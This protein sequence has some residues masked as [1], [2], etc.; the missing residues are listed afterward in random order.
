MSAIFKNP[1]CFYNE[2]AERRKHKLLTLK[3][4]WPSTKWAGTMKQGRWFWEKR[5]IQ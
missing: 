5:I 4:H 1:E 3:L 2:N